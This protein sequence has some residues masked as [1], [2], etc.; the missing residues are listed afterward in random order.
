[1]AD[2]LF[3]ALVYQKNPIK[4]SK[5][6]LHRGPFKIS[7]YDTPTSEFSSYFKTYVWSTRYQVH[8]FGEHCSVSNIPM[9]LLT[10]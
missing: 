7:E 1:M 5:K 9:H 8:A 10:L 4:N 6:L 2:L 3:L